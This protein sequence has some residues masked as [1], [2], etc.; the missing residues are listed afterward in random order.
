MK[1]ET[2]LIAV[3]VISL[4]F[5]GMLTFFTNVA[6]KT[7]VTYD[8]DSYTTHNGSQT[9][10]D[11]F[12]KIEDAKDSQDELNKQFDETFLN[13]ENAGSFWDYLKL[14]NAMG[15]QIY[16][17]LTTMKDMFVT[18]IEIVGLPAELF[19]LF[20]V[21]LVIFVVTIVLILLGRSYQ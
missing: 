1:I 18:T 12:N 17:S 14:G 21:I 2:P 10:E 13:P 19:Y 20:S 8:F 7:D 11:G 16:S 6:D 5:I 4:V 9:F 15:R 3:T